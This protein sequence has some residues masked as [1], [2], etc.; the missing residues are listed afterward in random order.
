MPKFHIPRRINIE[1]IYGCNAHCTM[2]NIDMKGSRKKGIMKLDLYKKTIDELAPYVDKIDEMDLWG[3]G[4]PLLDPHLFERIRY[5]KERNFRGIA[6]STNADLLVDEK[7]DQ[8]LE[9]KIDTVIFS[10]DG[11]KAETHEAIRVGVTFDKVIRYCE[12]I[13]E[14]RNK[15]NYPTRFVVRFIRQKSNRDQ[16]DDFVNFW[17][18]KL[19]KSRND[20]LMVHDMHDWSGD[21]ANEEDHLKYLVRQP[22][23]DAAPC[24]YVND[25]LYVLANGNV[26]LCAQDWLP[27]SW[28]FGNVN[29]TPPLEIYNNDK[30]NEVRKIHKEHR[31]MEMPLCAACTVWYSIGTRTLVDIEGK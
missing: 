19:S 21:I 1:N 22:E 12:E 28:I 29:D 4:E 27:S 8:L 7:Q 14:K 26:V 11:A 18:P 6:I 15:G 25:T 17:S 13:I 9:S 31:K 16:W 10:I 24:R 2:C 5:A 20:V 3:L 30:Y 23:I